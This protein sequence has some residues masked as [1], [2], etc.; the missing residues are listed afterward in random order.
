MPIK[1]Q[2]PVVELFN[3][4]DLEQ[5][6]YCIKLHC[7]MQID[8]INVKHLAS[9]CGDAKIAEDTN[10]L[11]FPTTANFVKVFHIAEG[12]SD[13]NHQAKLVKAMNCAIYMPP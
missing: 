1:Y 8:R 6:K 10:P 4:V 2:G 13:E 3:R 11:P 12:N 5:M 7:E 9:W